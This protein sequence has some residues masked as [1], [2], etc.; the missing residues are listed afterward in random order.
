MEIYNRKDEEIFEYWSLL[1]NM[2]LS[3]YTSKTPVIAQINGTCPAAGCL[4]AI[5]ADYRIMENNPKYKIGLNETQ[6]GFAA[7]DW[8]CFNYRGRA[9]LELKGLLVSTFTK[10]R[11]NMVTKRGAYLLN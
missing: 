7:P 3:L 10:N 5:A 1:Q 11:Q 2:W 8:L 6:L 9:F 4:M